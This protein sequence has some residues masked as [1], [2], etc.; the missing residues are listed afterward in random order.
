MCAGAP[1]N[2]NATYMPP[3]KGPRGTCGPVLSPET[4]EGCSQQPRLAGNSGKSIPTPCYI[5][6]TGWG[7]SSW[8]LRTLSVMNLEF[9][10]RYLEKKKHI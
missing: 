2:R 8:F 9:L 4:K 6:A 1:E 5:P 10:E 7:L 3:E